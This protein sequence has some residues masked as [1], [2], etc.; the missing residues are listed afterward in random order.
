MRRIPNVAATVWLN[1]ASEARLWVGGSLWQYMPDLYVTIWAPCGHW[2]SGPNLHQTEM[3]RLSL[4]YNALW[5]QKAAPNT[6]F[7]TTF[8][9]Y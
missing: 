6:D 9:E 2:G 5:W 3:S 8:T 1:W 4:I 7:H